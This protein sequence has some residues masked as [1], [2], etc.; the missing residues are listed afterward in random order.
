V[1]IARH[2][3]TRGRLA[4]D[5]RGDAA[6]DDGID[7]ARAEH[8][9]EVGALER[10]VSGLFKQDVARVHD[11]PLVKRCRLRSQSDI[12]PSRSMV[13]SA[14]THLSIRCR[15]LASSVARCI[16]MD[17]SLR[18]AGYRHLNMSLRLSPSVR[19]ERLVVRFSAQSSRDQLPACGRR[20]SPRATLD[21]KRQIEEGGSRSER[22]KREDGF[23]ARAPHSGADG[24]LASAPTTR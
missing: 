16:A 20:R 4:A 3:L 1:K 6:D 10:A 8:Q 24:R 13:Q 18:T 17:S 23:P 12:T 9:L 19:R 15:M 22:P 5:T 7:A 14:S 11:E 21:T 2:G